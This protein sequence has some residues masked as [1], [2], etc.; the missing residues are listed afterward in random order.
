MDNE[1][2]T[3]K[4]YRGTRR[5]RRSTRPRSSRSGG[6]AAPMTFTDTG[7]PAGST[8]TYRVAVSDPFNNTVTSTPV[9]HGHGRRRPR[10][11]TPPGCWPTPRRSTGGSVRR[12]APPRTTPSPRPTWP[13]PRGSPGAPPVRSPGDTAITANGT[14]TGRAATAV[15]VDQPGERVLAR[16]LGADDVHR[17][18]RDR[19]VQRGRARRPTSRNTDRA[20]YVD[21]GGRLSFGLSSRAARPGRPGTRRVR[22]T[23]PVNDGQWHHLVG[24]VG[25]AGTQAVRRRAPGGRRTRRLISGNTAGRPGLLDARQRLC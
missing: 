7:R 15:T 23:A 21:A 14:A 18:R 25:P 4:V 24:T 6:T 12:P 20:L 10:A 22:S 3:Y 13:R 17:R 16:D 8:A 5:R 11:P 1:N 9:Q 19:P 2:L